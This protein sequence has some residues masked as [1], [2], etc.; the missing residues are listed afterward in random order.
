MI[1]SDKPLSFATRIARAA[2]SITL[3]AAMIFTAAT[4][5][6]QDNEIP[7]DLEAGLFMQKCFSCHQ[8]L[9]TGQE[10]TNT[11]QRTRESLEETVHR[12]QQYTG[13]LPEEQITQLVDL[14]KD[15]EFVFRIE[16]AKLVQEERQ[17]AQ[18]EE[19]SA[20]GEV[21]GYAMLFM[22]S[23]AGCHNIGLGNASGI[24]LIH[25]LNQDSA[26]VRASVVRMQMQAGPL[27]DG[28]I[29]GL[30][31]LLQ[32]QDRVSRLA[33]VGFKNAAELQGKGETTEDAASSPQD[34]TGTTATTADQPQPGVKAE[35]HATSN[36]PTGM[37]IGLLLTTVIAA[38]G[39]YFFVWR[40]ED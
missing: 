18:T 31:A 29:D 40:N 21:D 33:S 32:D 2:A 15:E 9:L 11:H 3:A 36:F 17:H 4:A 20:E 28:Q 27:T 35:A 39:C 16:E 6:A 22:R 23:C 19:L 5:T 38:I 8:G 1:V 26:Q 30:T 25:T 14:M 34:T 10:L 13:P 37:I 12:M 7:E 24:D